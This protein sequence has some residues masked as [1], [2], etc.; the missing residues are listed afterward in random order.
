ME[1]V[2]S[3]LSLR[4]V[5]DREVGRVEL[6]QHQGAEP[7]RRR[8]P[9][10]ACVDAPDTPRRPQPEH[11]VPQAIEADEITAH[12]GIRAGEIKID[13]APGE[14]LARCAIGLKW[15]PENILR[16]IGT[17]ASL[18]HIRDTM[19]RGVVEPRTSR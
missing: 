16:D 18:L 7:V 17:R 15:I 6:G 11:A 2:A 3:R 5:G 10:S 19:L 4:L 9:H 8:V 13:D 12:K 1:E 14:M